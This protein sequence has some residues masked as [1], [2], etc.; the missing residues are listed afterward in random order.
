MKFRTRFSVVL[1]VFLAVVSVV[2][3]IPIIL[4]W[5]KNSTMGNLKGVLVFIFYLVILVGSLNCTYYIEGEYLVVK[6]LFFVKKIIDI[7]TINSVKN[8]R[9][10]ISSPAAS[11]RRLEIKY[12]EKRVILI[13]PA[14]QDVFIQELLKVNPKILVQL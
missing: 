13:S 6:Y 4:E 5:S 11:L 10:L 9:S 14:Y 8:S 1:L 3:F 7:Q 12:K 2:V